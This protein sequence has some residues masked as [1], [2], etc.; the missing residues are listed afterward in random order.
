MAESKRTYELVPGV[1]R[2][3][4]GSD[5]VVVLEAGKTFTTDDLA[6]AEFLDSCEH[7]RRATKKKPRAKPAKKPAAAAAPAASEETG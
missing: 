1:D 7:A 2:L 6:L 4:F 3:T 5:P